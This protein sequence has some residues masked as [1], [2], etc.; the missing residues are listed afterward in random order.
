MTSSV[1]SSTSLGYEGKEIIV[2]CDLSKSLPGIII[3]GLGAKA[4]DEAKERIRSAI[5]NSALKMPN[6][7]VTLNLAPADIPKDGT[8]YDLPMALAILLANETLTNTKF[9]A[10]S[11]FI[12]ELSLN[13]ALRPIKGV[14]T[15]VEVAKRSGKLRIFVPEENLKQA[16][17]IGGIDI[18]PCKNLA[19]TIEVLKNESFEPIG[20]TTGLTGDEKIPASSVD[21]ADIHGQAQ[22]K[23]AMEIAAA[24][25]HNILLNGSPGAGKT[26]MAK[27]L[28]SILPPTSKEEIVEI[29]KIHSLAG[30]TTEAIVTRPLRSPHHTSSAVS[31][32][33]GGRV[34]RPGEISLSHRGVLFLD[35]IPE[36][37]RS[38]LEALRQPMEDRTVQISRASHT[39]SY[40]ADFMLV[41]TQNPCPCGYALDE[42][43]DCNCSSLQISNYQKKLSG[44]LLDRIDMVIAVNK[45]KHS[46]LL[47]ERVAAEDSAAI[48]LRV[49]QARDA[50]K[51]RFGAGGKVNATMSNNEIKKVAKLK[52]E[53]KDFLDKCAQNLHLSARAYMKTI[54]VARTIA[55]L[56]QSEHIE[57]VHITEALQ[58]RSKR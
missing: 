35:E 3:V 57:I 39:S 8:S 48:R 25:H 44:P 22:G 36:F 53:A 13:G 43:R 46:L 32:I 11:S 6:Q 49:V 17:L 20:I 55:D 54:K 29:T 37:S 50:Q 4:I 5:K 34:P 42:D 15:H 1:H 28:L 9:I 56:E 2:E 14:I 33:G 45:I 24:G 26:M 41:A 40:P 12:G 47:S 19:S 18:V 30:E 21:Y 58:Y 10:D 7:R 31:I 51:V 38:T 23:R 16:S 27:A 52:P